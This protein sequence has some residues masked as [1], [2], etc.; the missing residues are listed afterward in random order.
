MY[1]Q[2]LARSTPTRLSNKKFLI[3]FIYSSQHGREI[4]MH[5]VTD[6]RA[7]GEIYKSLFAFFR[8]PRDISLCTFRSIFHGYWRI[9]R[10]YIFAQSLSFRSAF[11][12]KS[13]V[14]LP[15]GSDAYFWDVRAASAYENGLNV[16]HA[17]V[18]LLALHADDFIVV[19][20]KYLWKRRGGLH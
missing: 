2:I 16:L 17:Y 3:K 12:R 18:K 6:F 4:Y 19:F 5:I 8:W 13:L 11:Q 10:V 7:R 20:R 14:L 9:A 15:H 1:S